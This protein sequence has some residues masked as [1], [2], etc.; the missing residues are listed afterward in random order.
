MKCYMFTDSLGWRMN[1]GNNRN[2]A[3][4]IDAI[5]QLTDSGVKVLSGLIFY[6]VIVRMFNASSVGAIALFLAILGL[7]NIVFSLGFGSAAQHFTSFYLG[8][9]DYVSAAKV[10]YK[11]IK[12]G[13]AI[14]I[15]GFIVLFS[16]GQFL[17]VVFLHSSSYTELVRLLSIVLLGYLLFTILNGTLLGLQYFKLSA[18][19]NIV[20]WGFYYFGSLVIVFFNHSLYSLIAGWSIGIFMGVVLEL[21]LTLRF[22][23]HFKGEPNILSGQV[24]LKYSL[25]VLFSGLISYGA[26]YSDRFVVAG[27]LNLSSLGVYNFALLVSSAIGF[28]AAPFN[29]ILMAKFSE[30]FGR[31]EKDAIAVNVRTS[32]LLL[33]SFYVP[34]A[35]GI[36]ALSPV[37]L[38]LLGGSIYVAGSFALSIIMFFSSFFIAQNILTQAIASVKRTSVFLYSSTAALGSNVILSLILI[39]HLGLIGAALGYSSVAAVTFS[40]LY[41]Y[42]RREGIVYFDSSGT[43]KVWLSAFVMFLIVHASLKELGTSLYLLPVYIVVGVLIY[44]SMAKVLKFFKREDKETV[45]SMFPTKYKRLRTILHLIF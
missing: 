18:S 33:T 28:I 29:N 25:P 9:G 14:S 11:L 30:S 5:Y 12:Y 36:A 27:L 17:A 31:G 40:I 39:P 45:L 4:G 43:L 38:D 8:R 3:L 44:V 35:L 13:F 37:I 42:A 32:S 19:V 41:F 23:S 1:F 22:L 7:F 21:I 6:V 15:A 10:F 20:I 16:L 24:M 26:A 2:K 34:L